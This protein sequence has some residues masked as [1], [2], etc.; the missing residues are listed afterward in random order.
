VEEVGG[1]AN[2]LQGA[3]PGKSDGAADAGAANDRAA[4][5]GAAGRA[6]QRRVIMT[7]LTLGLLLAS[8]D[9]TVVG[10]SMPRIVG[11]LGGLDRFSW[12]FSAY[13][14]LATTMI[15]LAGKMSDRYGRK[16]V[17]L[18]G[19]SF[20]LGGSMLAGVS[21]NMDQLII[22]RAL[23]GFGGGAMLPVA[24]ATVADLYPPAERGKLQ[25]ALGA[26]FAVASIIGPFVGGWIV[27]NVN[28]RWVFYVNVPLG[29]LAIA[30]TTVKFPKVV[31]DES[32]PIDYAGIAAI[33]TFIS[34]F[35]LIT[36]W[37]GETYDWF[38]WQIL[39]L[40]AL[41]LGAIG[42]FALIERR[43]A[44]PVLPLRLFKSPVFT[45]SAVS[46][47]LMAMGLFG[48]IAFLPMFLQA[49]VGFTATYSG[50]VL[51]PLMIS[52]M[53]GAIIS[54]ASLKRTGYKVWLAIGPP[55]GAFGLYLLSTLHRGSPI[56][57]TVAYLF[58]TGLGLGFTMSNYIVVAQNVVERKDLGVAS[59]TMSLFRALGGTIGV[60]VMGVLVNRRMASEAPNHLSP[61]LAALLPSTDLN[62]LGGLVLSDR[63]KLFPAAAIDGVRDALGASIVYIFFI[64]MCIVLVAWVVTLCIKSVPLKSTDEYL[65]GKKPEGPAAAGR[66]PRTAGLDPNSQ[67]GTPTQHM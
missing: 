63:A 36:F 23:Q 49:V 39:G 2:G 50:E 19:M 28:W 53:L 52:V 5:A 6:R 30:V 48:V 14:L 25:G 46:L 54:G 4:D 42:V 61:Q 57:H 8:L 11:E 18:F 37:G 47:M 56:E 33:T 21:Q 12:I 62:T 38:S 9:Q 16:A 3:E 17:F 31:S 10:T 41:S 65:N 67:R 22:F 51:V 64:A 29:A 45:L 1:K 15:P 44:D 43:A 7:G 27:D 58:I 20:F 66:E 13:M 24:V 35:L 60:T 26:V 32:K 55:I 34:A 59:S 40:A